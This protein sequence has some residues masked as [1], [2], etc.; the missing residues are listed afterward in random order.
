L[1]G[2]WLAVASPGALAWAADKPFLSARIDGKNWTATRVTAI[3]FRFGPSPALNITGVLDGPPT[4]RLSFNLVLAAE[5]E[6]D[7]DYPLR[8][9]A[10]RTSHGNFT[11]NVMNPDAPENL[12]TI[13]NGILSI[14]RHDAASGTVSGSFSAIATDA[15]RTRRLLI[16]D[17][18]FANI[19]VLAGR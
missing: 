18:A 15:G 13:Q 4:S 1:L 16:T 3:T 12:F 14:A 7:Q 17:G 8:P 10:A 9:A 2:A 11:F 19:P 5:D 6:Y